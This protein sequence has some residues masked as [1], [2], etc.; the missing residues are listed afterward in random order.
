MKLKTLAAVVALLAVLSAAAYWINRPAP[1]PAADPRVGQPLIEASAIDASSG[2]RFSDQGK[3]I[4]LARDADGTWRDTSYF[5]LPADFQKLSSFVNDLSSSKVQRFV[6]AN[7]E[8]I[9]RLEFKD[10]RIEVLGADGKPSLSVTLGR[11]TDGGGRFVAFG[12]LSRAYLSTF[13]AWLDTDPKGWADAALAAF[14]S[15]DVRGVAIFFDGTPPLRLSR[16]K[17]GDAWTADPATAGRRV[18]ADAVASLLTTLGSLRFS[19]TGAH[20]DPEAAVARRHA[21]KV[22]VTLFSGPTVEFVLGRRP[23]ERKLKAPAAQKP[24]AAKAVPG[25][26][27]PAEARPAAPEFDVVPAGPVFAFVSSSDPK[28]PVNALMRK[29]ACQIDEYAFTSLPQK[30]DDLLEAAP[31][32]AKAAH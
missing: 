22:V 20:S 1:A 24:A 13:N 25:R 27:N 8:R 4:E 29:R 6:S 5:D 32:P 2:L 23:E 15:D 17:K 19:D 7:P 14:K 11:N 3:T 30:P 9:G 10:T 18:N 21:R 16:A 26:E 31:A 12:N 28:A